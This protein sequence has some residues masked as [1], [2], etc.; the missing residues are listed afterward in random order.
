MNVKCNLEGHQINW[1]MAIHICS[2][3]LLLP[4]AMCYLHSFT[5][6]ERSCKP[7]KDNW[8]IHN[9][10]QQ[11]ATQ[12][13]G[14]SGIMEGGRKQEKNRKW[15][16][17]RR[18][19]EWPHPKFKTMLSV[20]IG[21]LFNVKIGVLSRFVYIVNTTL[22]KSCVFVFVQYISTELTL[23]SKKAMLKSYSP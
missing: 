19:G 23:K 8:Y 4:A 11:D 16:R 6:L 9:K 14:W 2:N 21:E 18:I 13:D 12:Q 1:V 10:S 20:E 7:L 3:M 22:T 15:Q 5:P 17:E